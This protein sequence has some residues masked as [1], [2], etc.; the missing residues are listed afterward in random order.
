VY[1]STISVAPIE[2]QQVT[3]DEI[4]AEHSLVNANKQ[5]IERM[6]KKI[7]CVLKRV[8]GEEE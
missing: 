5:L 7:E 3:V 4:E 2:V 8:W 1:E 6:E